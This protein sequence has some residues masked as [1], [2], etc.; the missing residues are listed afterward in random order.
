MSHN[1]FSPENRTV[2]DNVEKYAT[3]GQATDGSYGPDD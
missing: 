1:F 2:W 3:A